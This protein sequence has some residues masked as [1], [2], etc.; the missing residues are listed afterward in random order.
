MRQ[1]TWTHN[2]YHHAIGAVALVC[3]LL[4]GTA[5]AL[6]VIDFEQSYYVHDGHQVWDFC[7]VKHYGLYFIFYGS[8]PMDGSDP[9]DSETIWRSSS[10][11]LIHWTPP[12]AMVTTSGLAHESEAVWA[13]D[14][15]FDPASQLWWLAYTGVDSQ[16]N[17][18][19]CIAYS[20]GLSSWTKSP[21]NPIQEPS[22]PDFVY[23]PDSGWGSCRDPFLF[24]DGSTWN[25]L[26]TVMTADQPG[27]VAGLAIASSNSV[28]SWTDPQVFLVSGSNVPSAS[29]E[30]PQ[31]HERDGRHHLFF[32]EYGTVGV[33]HLG[34]DDP[35]GWDFTRRTIIDLGL[36]PEVDSF[37]GGQ[38]YLL[39]RV[40][41]YLEPHL[42]ELAY[43]MR[44]DTLVFSDDENQVP[45]VVRASPLDREFASYNG[46][47][48]LGNPTF[49]DNPRRRGEDSVG[50]VGNSYFGSA[51]YFQGPLSGRGQAGQQLGAVATGQL[52]SRV[53]TI[54][55]T[56]I[57]LLVGGTENLETCYVALMDADADTVLCKSTG[58]GAAPM[59]ERW[60]NT[61]GLLGREVYVK[62]VDADTEGFI[63]VDEI[64]E[65]MVLVGVS[66]TPRAGLR[67]L[68]PSPNPGNPQIAL[69]F[70][71]DTASECTAAV[72]DLRGRLVWRSRSMLVPAGPSS[73][74]WPGQEQGGRRAA[75]G[76]YVYRV[77]TAR[78]EAVSGKITLVP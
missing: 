55:G 21:F 53:F 66:E 5:S 25:V 29:L 12:A 11:D 7:L 30:S 62:I 64:R 15:V 48:V 27:G 44:T 41:P 10:S 4:A 68:G 42:D 23:N 35:S 60:W 19:L 8:V 18:R 46:N 65:T 73:V 51:E 59:T 76:V 47:S 77:S 32:H 71:V 26:S 38:S 45:S 54:T 56:S 31:Y 57:S 37:D 50:L 6:H 24:H 75:G 22:P 39:S 63:N 20:S 36:A 17:Q 13:P 61:Y 3:L 2:P 78:G 28:H 14:V 58:H 1:R 67:D 33:S 49:G 69:R 9:F 40:G 72:Y 43:V 70:A 34:A 74:V 52:S 16:R